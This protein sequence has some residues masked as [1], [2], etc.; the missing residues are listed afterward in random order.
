MVA[1]G[2][3]LLAARL[4][5]LVLLA[6]FALSLWPGRAAAAPPSQ[7]VVGP[8]GA[9]SLEELLEPYAYGDDL[10]GGWTLHSADLG[11][12][13]KLWLAPPDA[14]PKTPAEAYASL[15][16]IHPSEAADQDERH[17]PVS[18][19]VLQ[20]PETSRPAI[21]ALLTALDGH[22]EAPDL[23]LEIEPEF[24]LPFKEAPPPAQ[25][26]SSSKPVLQPDFWEQVGR[27]ALDGLVSMLVLLG[28]AVLLAA[29]AMRSEPSRL[30]WILLGIVVVGAA[31]RLWLAHSV[32]MA[33]YPYSRLITTAVRIGEGPALH[34]L[35][36]GPV[37]VPTL[38]H[39]SN[40]AFSLLAPLAAFVHARCLLD[41]TRA[42]L[43][44]A[45]MMA[46]LPM[47]IRFSA[48]DAAFV[49]SIT[50]SS[51][52]F[53]LVHTATRSSKPWLGWLS[54]AL[55]VV[56]LTT[57]YL[58]RPLNMLY[59]PL[60]VA[61]VF[62]GDGAFAAKGRV[63]WGRAAAVL[64]VVAGTTAAV[65]LPHLLSNFGQETSE[66][67]SLATF[68]GA[69]WVVARPE[70]NIIVHPSFMPP[71]I[72][73]LAML[74]VASLWVRGRR[75]LL[76]FLVGWFVLFFVAHGYIVPS[77]PFMQARY[78]L[79]L[80]VPFALLAG[81]GAETLWRRWV[82]A[83]ND[84]LW[85]NPRRATVL[86]FGL[87]GYLALSPLLHLGTI[88]DID[89]NDQREF[90]FVQAARG[91]IPEQCTIVEYLGFEGE[92]RFS[93]IASR[94]EPP[95]KAVPPSWAMITFSYEDS[96]GGVTLPES[97]RLALESEGCL[98]V[99]NGMPC[100]SGTPRLLE[101]APVC[102][103]AAD[104]L[105]EL[106]RETF[107]S[108]PYHEPVSRRTFR[109]QRL[110]LELRGR[111]GNEQPAALDQIP[112]VSGCEQTLAGRGGCSLLPTK[113]GKR[114][115][116]ARSPHEVPR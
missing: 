2:S 111:L 106:R 92:S 65:G 96:S 70:L 28:S 64:A 9:A 24:D 83:R 58:I 63:S 100:W 57:I 105:P 97:A 87:V 81:V 27:W 6:G 44:V 82:A 50:T 66:G 55:V 15:R 91:A 21:D 116:G 107:D 26:K 35:V 1:V 68:A 53:A 5:G 109:G 85:L 101:R 94:Y 114:P 8:E 46:V 31:L 12:S 112:Q 98:V 79:H 104:G 93:R 51:V 86:R 72:T 18:T 113:A 110:E 30:R 40:L 74:G 39:R 88:R 14:T 103:E 69:L 10:A 38:I 42:A 34:R 36:E 49:A 3:K 61:T 71:G 99:Y 80:V 48:S 17:G 47:H 67:L 78:H 4:L 90:L 77:E 62:V 108:R 11:P 59:F 22:D 75:S 33:P 84:G 13:I 43:F 76:A 45:G 56:P 89:F 54:V 95:G 19:R 16:I 115:G 73:L 7:R 29:S 32:P 23:W 52:A 41:D 20:Q 102:L 60:F 25:A 37:W